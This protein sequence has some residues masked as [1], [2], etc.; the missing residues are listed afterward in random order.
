[1]SGIYGLINLDGAPVS[2]DSLAAMR[3]AMHE[4]GTDGGTEWRDASAG[5]GS[6]IRFNTP[7]AIYEQLPLLSSRGFTLTAAARLDNREELFADLRT[8]PAE[9]PNT[10]DGRL[11]LRAYETW[12]EEAP[13]HL[14][15][16]WSFAAWH[17]RDKKLFLARDHFG[18][19]GLY[20]FQDARRFMF[21]SSRKAL[22]ALAIPRR[23]NEWFLACGLV[24]WSAHDGPQTIEL[25]LHRLPPAHT[26]RLQDGATSIQ[27][28]WR[29]EDTPELP[30]R[31]SQE[32]AEGLLAVY[33]RAVRD[34]LRSYRGIGLFLS[35]GLDSGSTAVLAARALRE[36]G[37]RLTAYTSAPAYDVGHMSERQAIGDEVPL[38][39]SVAASAGNIDLYE[40]RSW[41][42][43]P[44]EGIRHNL[45]IHAE[46]GHAAANGFWIHE[47]LAAAQDQ[48]LGTMLT[49][50][51]GN[52]TIS[53]NGRNRG[54]TLNTLLRARLWSRAAQLLVYP[55]VP[56]PLIRRLRLVLH[57][58]ELDWSHTSIH[59]EFARRIGLSQA[60]VRQ[61]GD[62]TKREDWYPP[63]QERYA[64]I[65]PGAS[66]VGSIWAEN[67][68]A[69]SLDIRDATFDKR[70]LEFV[71]AVPD[72]EYVGPEGYNRWLIRLT[73]QG[74]LPDDVR[75]NRRHGFQA[76]D[77]CHRLIASKPEVEQTLSEIGASSLAQQYLN[78]ERMRQ[79]WAL[80]QRHV[81]Y[82]STHQTLTILARGIMAGLFLVSL[83]GAD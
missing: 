13:H 2:D 48:C 70:V 82:E 47:V 32:Y 73:M 24:S 20:Y 41:E 27:Q 1:M 45:E 49:G 14:L 67:G 60:Y 58:G 74:L 19:T 52:A 76:A 29:L 4:W 69:H 34:R 81:D 37:A 64:I 56:V 26:L 11:V 57:S 17:P 43:T 35:G 75:L 54:R 3:S 6:L 7:E 46:P 40:I 33:D 42:V 12:G 22:H 25:D 53:W 36:Q 71:I 80:M 9:W 28:F 38:A 23:L 78:L 30:L 39:R 31:S 15:G 59:P 63:L 55:H 51:G 16:D 83:E 21:A 44:I 8:S 5:L 66:F 10:P 50:Q 61:S 72:R 65:R 62:A 77:L 79:V 18:N 68:A